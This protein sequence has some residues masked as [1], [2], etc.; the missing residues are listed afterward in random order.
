MSSLTLEKMDKINFLITEVSLECL[1]NKYFDI[2]GKQTDSLLRL[3]SLNSMKPDSTDAVADKQ[4]NLWKSLTAEK[5]KPKVKINNRPVATSRPQRK[6]RASLSIVNNESGTADT[7]ANDPESLLVPMAP[8]AAKITNRRSTISVQLAKRNKAAPIH[9][10]PMQTKT[11]KQTSELLEEAKAIAD[12]VNDLKRNTEARKFRMVF[13]LSLI[14]FSMIVYVFSY[15]FHGLGYNAM[16]LLSETQEDKYR[17]LN[18]N[19]VMN[20]FYTAEKKSLFTQ[21]NTLIKF[22]K[23][24]QDDRDNLQKLKNVRKAIFEVQSEY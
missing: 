17:T 3:I 14:C 10:V 4:S 6:R 8:K 16:R 13:R 5:V 2:Y 12:I 18:I 24:I 11:R 22:I 21:C 9:A 20:D 19:P 7:A 23:F 15:T 1:G